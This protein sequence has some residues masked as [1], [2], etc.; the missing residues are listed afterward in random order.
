MGVGEWGWMGIGV[1]RWRRIERRFGCGGG[2]VRGSCKI[3]GCDGV[4]RK[5]DLFVLI[6]FRFFIIKKIIDNF[7]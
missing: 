1:E 4:G 2:L 6:L 3:G 7:F 5:E